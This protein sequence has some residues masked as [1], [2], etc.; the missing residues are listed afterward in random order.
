LVGG[1][2]GS[3]APDK[4]EEEE[5]E[6][7]RLHLLEGKAVVVARAAFHSCYCSLRHTDGC[8]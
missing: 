3:A 1:G 5:L 4:A 7:D 6:E 8:R 2:G